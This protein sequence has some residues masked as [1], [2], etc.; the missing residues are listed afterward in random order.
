MISS[1]QQLNAKPIMKKLR[2]LPFAL[3]G[4]IAFA[5][6]SNPDLHPYLQLSIALLEAKLGIVI[7]YLLA[8]K[9]SKTVVTLKDK[10]GK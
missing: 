5:F 4:M 8:K 3:V 1:L 9:L 10:R 2:F 7:V 6:S